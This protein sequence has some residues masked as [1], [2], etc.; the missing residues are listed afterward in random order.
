MLI[1]SF[2]GK[3]NFLSN[4]YDAPAVLDD[5]A[6]PTAEHAF[7]AAKTLSPSTRRLIRKESTPGRA[8]R[9]GRSLRLRED[10]EEIKISV[11]EEIVRSKFEDPELQ[12]RLIDTFPA[13]LI[14]GNNWGDQFWGKTVDG[15]GRN[16]LGKILMRLRKEFMKT[17]TNG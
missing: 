4:F 8:K 2:S 9:L 13:V 3:Y 11:M 16:E 14:E 12:Q 5:V 7:Q 10:W 6:Y 1:T 17:S 15:Q